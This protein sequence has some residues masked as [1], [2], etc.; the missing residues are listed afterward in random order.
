MLHYEDGSLQYKGEFVNGK[1]EGHGTL[2]FSSGAKYSG[3]FVDGN[4]EGPGKLTWPDGDFKSG[5]FEA[6]EFMTGKVKITMRNESEAEG[7][8]GEIESVYEGEA[9]TNLQPEGK[10]KRTYPNGDYEEGLFSEGKLLTGKR[11]RSFGDGTIYE[12]GILNGEMHDEGEVIYIWPSGLKYEGQMFEGDFHGNGK[13]QWPNGDYVDGTFEN[14]RFIQGEVR[15]TAEDGSIYE[16]TWEKEMRFGYGEWE[17]PKTGEFEK[18]MW[19]EDG[20]YSGEIRRLENGKLVDIDALEYYLDNAWAEEEARRRK[21]EAEKARIAAEALAKRKKEER[22]RARIQKEREKAAK[23]EAAEARKAE[24]A[25]KKEEAQKDKN[26]L[27]SF[28][29][30]YKIKL[31]QAKHIEE[32]KGR[33]FGMVGIILS[34]GKT[35]K[36]QTNSKGQLI[37]RDITIEYQGKKI[38][39]GFVKDQIEMNDRDIIAGRAGTSTIKILEIRER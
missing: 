8:P 13:K 25:R 16:G 32:L 33:E 17:N 5:F 1:M 22:E 30:S 11:K 31:T 9:T 10:G 28:N 26:K 27:R 38:P 34:G 37:Q 35:E 15:K 4:M 24:A 2:M 14:D 6:D 39:K 7:E 20:I 19:D 3:E 36:I 23:K 12:G 18:G 29:V 21:V